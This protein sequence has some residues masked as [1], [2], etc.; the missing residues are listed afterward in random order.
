VKKLICIVCPNGCRLTVEAQNCGFAVSGNKCARG[1]T[2]AVNEMT[3]PRRSV[4]S[5]VRTSFAGIPV[6]PVRTSSDIPKDRIADLVRLLGGVTVTRNIGIGEA[7][8]TD[9][10][11]LG[12]DVI[13]SSNVL[14]D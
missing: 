14:K 1:E 4:T 8:I 9:A 11:N 7:V 3:D 12:V 2:F 10:L 13:A 6:I 5:T